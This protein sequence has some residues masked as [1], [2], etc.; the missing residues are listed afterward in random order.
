MIFKKK[1]KY[2]QFKIYYIESRLIIKA[3]FI[4]V[5]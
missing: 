3:K 5:Y 1:K 2:E 4:K